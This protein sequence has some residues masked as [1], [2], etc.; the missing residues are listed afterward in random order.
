MTFHEEALKALEKE[1][2]L[3][4]LFALPVRA[5]RQD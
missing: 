2:D 3:D 4:K 5:H 1:A